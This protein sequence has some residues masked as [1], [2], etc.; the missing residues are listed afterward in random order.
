MGRTRDAFKGLIDAHIA[1]LRAEISDIAGQITKMASLGGLAFALLLTMAN[2]LYIGGFLFTGE[3][4]FGSI[5]WGLL[6][7]VAFAIAVAVLAILLAVGATMGRQV[8]AMILAVLI[9]IAVTVLLGSNVLYN[10]AVTAGAQLGALPTDVLTW[11]AIGAVDFGVALFIFGLA[12]GGFRSGLGMLVVGAILGAVVGWLLLSRLNAT[13]VVAAVGG[14]VVFAVVGFIAGWFA[15]R[16]RGAIAGLAI[17]ELVGLA[18]GFLFAGIPW[19]W[20]PAAGF[21]VTL[22][23]VAWPLLGFALAWPK[24]DL[25]EYFSRLQPRE[26]IAAVTET[27]EWLQNQAQSRLP[28]RGK[29]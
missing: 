8:L 11:V 22:G 23:L 15:G 9:T 4:L 25:E 3:V 6:Q 17:G 16:L 24:L 18:V 26:S 27:K 19:D 13:G 28:R 14:A 12:T 1:L 5:G 7:G 21:G 10:S 20:A 29:Q 2:M